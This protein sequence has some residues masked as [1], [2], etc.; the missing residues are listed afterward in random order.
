MYLFSMPLAEALAGYQRYEKTIVL[1]LVGC[2]T[3]FLLVYMGLFLSKI[4]LPFSLLC[5][6]Q[7]YE[8]ILQCQFKDLLRD[9]HVE[10][11]KSYIIYTEKES[12]YLYYLTHYDLWSKSVTTISQEQ[13]GRLEELLSNYAYMI[14]W[15]RNPELEEWLSKN[16]YAYPTDEERYVIPLL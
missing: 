16:G 10:N 13:L 3:I 11:E 12:G 6:K 9:S 5:Q 14:V 7:H 1:F 4:R 2:F 8:S 15:E